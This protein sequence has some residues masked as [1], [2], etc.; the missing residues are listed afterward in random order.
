MRKVFVEVIVKYTKNGQKVPITVIWEDGTR[1]DIDK[2]VDYKRAASL[3]VGRQGMRF[4]CRIRGKDTYL[5]LEDDRWF[6][7]AK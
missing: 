3:K 2:V 4:L 7:E 1:Y 5:W 6:V